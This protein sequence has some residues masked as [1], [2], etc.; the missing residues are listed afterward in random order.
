MPDTNLVKR[1]L[2][3]KLSQ[4]Q[5][6]VMRGKSK[7][8]AKFNAA[9]MSTG[10]TLKHLRSRLR[11]GDVLLGGNPRGES[12]GVFDKLYQKVSDGLLGKSNKHAA[13][14]VGKGN[15]VESGTY[16]TRKVRLK[17]FLRDRRSA[18]IMRA[19]TSSNQER[20]GAAKFAESKVGTPYATKNIVGTL[21]KFV[22]KKIPVPSVFHEKNVNKGVICSGLVA[23]SYPGI[24]I[25]KDIPKGLTRPS[26]IRNSENFKQVH[27]YERKGKS[28]QFSSH[29]NVKGFRLG[30]G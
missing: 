9:K 19:H 22:H 30:R 26:D 27:H 17:K 3:L 16:G 8:K 14:Y 13:M 5:E 11:S 23:H 24:K 10:Q 29:N 25:D 15:V 21:I 28:S 7:A 4:T 6:K 20:K 12:S 2:K 1:Q 18:S